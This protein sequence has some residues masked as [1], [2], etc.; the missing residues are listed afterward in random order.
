MAP[1]G[2]ISIR[3]MLRPEG[4]V[5]GHVA[6]SLLFTSSVRSMVSSSLPTEQFQRLGGQG[7]SRKVGWICLPIIGSAHGARE[8]ARESMAILVAASSPRE[9]LQTKVRGIQAASCS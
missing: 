7:G 3:Q 9:D 2:P 5:V 1:A 4:R 6:L 8:S